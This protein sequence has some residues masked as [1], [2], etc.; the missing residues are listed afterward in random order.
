MA[1]ASNDILPLFVTRREYHRHRAF[2]SF[3]LALLFMIRK[4]K[5][6]LLLASS[7]SPSSMLTAGDEAAE[8]VRDARYEDC[9]REF[10]PRF[11]SSI[12]L[13]FSLFVF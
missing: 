6:D 9:D 3:P 4:G 1:L 12:R 13:I 10:W 7:R 5:S 11:R 8:N 2:D